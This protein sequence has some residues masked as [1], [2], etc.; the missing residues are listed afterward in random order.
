[1]FNFIYRAKK[2]RNNNQQYTTGDIQSSRNYLKLYQ[3]NFFHSTFHSLQPG[4]KLDSKC[5]IRCLNPDENRLLRSCGRLQCAPTQFDLEKRPIILH[6][7]T[8]LFV[9]AWN[10]L[11]RYVFIST[12]NQQKPSY[13]C[14][15]VI[16]LC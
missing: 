11:I 15:H 4:T 14:Y 7:R 6:S 3:D 5:K 12:Q 9:C 16:G 8:K 13:K 2:M 10:M 1:M